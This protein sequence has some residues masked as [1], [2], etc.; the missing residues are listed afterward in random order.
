M[1]P[2][3]HN[4]IYGVHL[5]PLKVKPSVLTIILGLCRTLINRRPTLGTILYKVY[6]VVSLNY[7]IAIR[8][9]LCVYPHNIPFFTG[10]RGAD[11]YPIVA[12]AHN[13]KVD[14]PF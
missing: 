3:G 13:K 1:R 12:H 4:S 7:P 14:T 5:Q 6:I 11:I 8:P 2:Y 9:P 10:G